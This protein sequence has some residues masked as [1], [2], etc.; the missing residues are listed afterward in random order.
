MAYRAVDAQQT[1]EAKKSP[2]AANPA[3][4]EWWGDKLWKTKRNQAIWDAQA[5]QNAL[6]A[7]KAQNAAAAQPG[8]LAPGGTK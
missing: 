8:P 7:E 1:I 2:I 6:A 5:A 3:S 4:T